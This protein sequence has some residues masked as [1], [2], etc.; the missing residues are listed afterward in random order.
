MPHKKGKAD[1]KLS[2]NY[3]R[4][5][6]STSLAW[7]SCLI[8]VFFNMLMHWSKSFHFPHAPTSYLYVCI[9][10][11]VLYKSFIKFELLKM[12]IL[13]FYFHRDGQ[14]E[15][16]TCFLSQGEEEFIS[17]HQLV[18]FSKNFQPLFNQDNALKFRFLVFACNLLIWFINTYTLVQKKTINYLS[19]VTRM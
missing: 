12:W 2:E 6:G 18:I 3:D 7:N 9:K 8:C 14:L 13:L 16:Q 4:F 17:W 15:Q 19:I 1:L 11:S 10:L 5:H